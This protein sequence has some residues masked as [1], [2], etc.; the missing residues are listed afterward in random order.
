MQKLTEIDELQA[1]NSRLDAENRRLTEELIAQKRYA[2]SLDKMLQAL[3]FLT[4]SP[5]PEKLI[6][7]I[8]DS[9]SCA[10]VG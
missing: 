7:I 9:N 4:Q 1:E 10:P 8:V 6:V 5:E 2:F 3:D